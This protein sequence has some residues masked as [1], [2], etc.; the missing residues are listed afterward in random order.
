MRASGP[1]TIGPE[2]LTQQYS[3]MYRFFYLL[4]VIA[5]LCLCLFLGFPWWTAAVVGTVLAV[6]FPLWRR[7]A[8]W[9]A[10]LAGLL[11]WGFYTGYLHL[12]SEGRLTDRLAVTFGLGTGWGLVGTT[13]AWGALT[14]ALGGWFGAS[15]RRAFVKTPASQESPD[16]SLT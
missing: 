7:G 6:V 1:T 4:A 9:F 14:T 15:V 5:A 8:F 11:T 16:G 2:A 3:L 10:F 13:A 12:W